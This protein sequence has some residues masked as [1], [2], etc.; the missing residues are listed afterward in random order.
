MEKLLKINFLKNKLRYFSTLINFT[1][2]SL[3]NKQIKE[4]ISLKVKKSELYCSYTNNQSKFF[5]VDK[6][7][8][9]SPNNHKCCEPN[10]TVE[11]NHM[12]CFKIFLNSE[13]KYEYDSYNIYECNDLKFYKLWFKKYEKEIMMEGA[14]D[15]I[16]FVAT[17]V[18][19]LDMV[20]Y[21]YKIGH[22]LNSKIY[23]YLQIREICEE[24]DKE[25]V[26]ID[27]KFLRF[28]LENGC[29]PN[30]AIPSYI[31]EKD[32][33]D[34]FKL[35]LEYEEFWSSNYVYKIEPY[36]GDNKCWKYLLKHPRYTPKWGRKFLYLKGKSNMGKKFRSQY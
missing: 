28:L 27:E 26:K 20:E 3:T 22:K 25:Q 1:Y 14:D 12:E 10:D 7:F 16:V 21:L 2:L 31:M 13:T 36:F 33:I 30:F 19:R 9:Q 11:R 6:I 35:L 5:L 24:S 8:L 18:E 29:P 34:D 23:G 4:L 17:E 15:E 32:L